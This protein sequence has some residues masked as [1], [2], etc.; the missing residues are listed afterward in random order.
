MWLGT[1]NIDLLLIPSLFDSMAIPIISK[2]FPAPTSWASK[3]FPP[4]KP[5]AMASF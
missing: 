5:L 1:T 3:V 4:N 2:V